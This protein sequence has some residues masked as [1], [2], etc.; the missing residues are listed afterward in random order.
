MQ[1]APSDI[2]LTPET[3]MRAPRWNSLRVVDAVGALVLTLA[4]AWT[5]EV[6]RTSGADARPQVALMLATAATLMATRLLARINRS[7]P[8]TLVIVIGAGVALAVGSELWSQRAL[9]APFHYANARGAFFAFPAIAGV[10]MA[11]RAR[12]PSLFALGVGSALFFASVPVLSGV[13]APTLLL[14][15]LALPAWWIASAGA[16][17]ARAVVMAC[18]G[19]FFLALATSTFIATQ[20][21]PKAPTDSLDKALVTSLTDYRLALWHDAFGIMVEHPLRGVGPGR[22]QDYSPTAFGEPDLRWAH[23]EFLQQGA[24]QGVP[25]LILLAVLF[26]WGFARLVLGGTPDAITALAAAALATLGV[27]AAVD[28]VLHFPA[29]PLLA[30]ALI[31]GGMVRATPHPE[32]KAAR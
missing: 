9:S 30:A 17:R 25:G 31:G 32:S 11:V 16:S 21:F 14:I 13:M 10:M 28:Y 20:R 8:A 23:N 6:G 15:L 7:L 29:I 22:F 3:P 2:M 24:E 12:R 5:F 4:V 27:H 18:A 19:V 1:T 26:G